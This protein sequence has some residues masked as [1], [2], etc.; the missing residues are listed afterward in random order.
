MKDLVRINNE[1][2]TGYEKAAHQN[3][4][5]DSD[6][7]FVFLKMAEDRRTYVK[8]LNEKIIPLE[9]TRPTILP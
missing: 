6:L 5:S 1:R 2:I 9:L 8:E 3:K 4:T 7:Q